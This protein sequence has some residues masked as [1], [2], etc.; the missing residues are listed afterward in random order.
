MQVL[1]GKGYSIIINGFG[2]QEEIHSILAECRQLGARLAERHGADLSDPKQ[3]E[4]LFEFVVDKCGHGP[5]VLVNNA[6]EDCGGC[7]LLSLFLSHTH[8]HSL[9]LSPVFQFNLVPTLLY[10]L[11]SL[12]HLLPLSPLP[13]R[14]PTCISH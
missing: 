12:V 10:T 4:H 1:A 6:G 2:Q 14:Y 7:A 11:C 9:A 3:I 8:T 5:D 13:C